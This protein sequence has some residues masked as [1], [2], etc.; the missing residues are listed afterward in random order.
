MVFFSAPKAIGVVRL[1]L[2]AAAGNNIECFI[3]VHVR[4]LLARCSWILCFVHA[5][6]VVGVVVTGL[7]ASNSTDCHD[8]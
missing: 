4:D 8:S 5:Q 3:V 7:Q 6:H 2:V 1:W